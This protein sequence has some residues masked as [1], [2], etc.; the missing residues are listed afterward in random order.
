MT[1]CPKCRSSLLWK[2]HHEDSWRCLG[3]DVVSCLPS[4][5]APLVIKIGG[6]RVLKET[7][8]TNP[9]TGISEL[10]EIVYGR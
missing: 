10:D 7:L 1:Y 3:C 5:P 8:P 6:V 2:R 9:L 4:A